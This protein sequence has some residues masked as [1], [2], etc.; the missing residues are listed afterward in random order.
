MGKG[1]TE[2]I[3]YVSASPIA[4]LVMRS[5]FDNL[6]A[7]Q[8]PAA[9]AELHDGEDC[10]GRSQV[11]ENFVEVRSTRSIYRA[12]A[13]IGADGACRSRCQTNGFSSYVPKASGIALE[14]ESHLPGDELRNW[15]TTVLVFYGI[16][17]LSGYAWLFPEAQAASMGMGT[18]MPLA[19]TLSS[20]FASRTASLGVDLEQQDLKDHPIPLGARPPL[21][22]PPPGSYW[23][24]TLPAYQ[25]LC[26]EKA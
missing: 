22:P 2:P 26:P 1:D 15:R 4:Y 7:Q 25:T 20:E 3:E 21:L 24:G 10:Q 23:P 19:A 18:F 17:H 14:I 16:P 13:V 12:A 6:L 9:G 11:T 8:A 5:S